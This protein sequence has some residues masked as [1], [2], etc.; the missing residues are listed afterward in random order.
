[1][2]GSLFKKLG[3]VMIHPS[4]CLDH[5]APT[6][7]GSE[8]IYLPKG[9]QPGDVLRLHGKGIPRLYRDGRRDQ[10]VMID[11]RIPKNLSRR[12]EKLL[13]EFAGLEKGTIGRQII[14]CT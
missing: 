11:V 1:M 5:I 12:Q 8:K 14:V 6:L 4:L 10:I 9:T 13:W 2:D 3:Q 7:E